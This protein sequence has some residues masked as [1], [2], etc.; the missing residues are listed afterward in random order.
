MDSLFVGK[1][2]FENRNIGDERDTEQALM[3]LDVIDQ[4]FHQ[5][6]FPPLSWN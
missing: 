3:P 2:F 1:D 4:E 6:L 5:N